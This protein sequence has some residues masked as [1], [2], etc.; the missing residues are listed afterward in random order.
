MSEKS[1]TEEHLCRTDKETFQLGVEIGK[2]LAGGEI[3]L[4]SGG[5]GA[6]KTLITKGIVSA[7]GFDENEV[8]SPSF[9]IV[10]IYPTEKF[11]VYHVDL[12]R[13]E[14]EN[15]PSVGLE[16]ILNDEKS[17]VIIEW[18]D[19]IKN[20][21]TLPR[22]KIFVK[23]EGEGDQERRIFVNRLGLDTKAEDLVF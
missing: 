19:R 2:S 1:D 6:G 22:K 23:I 15:D 16:E 12:W 11:N 13:I 10:N 9:T 8:N 3:V 17:I 18:A 20:S 4:L 21:T 14:N 7:L 5:L